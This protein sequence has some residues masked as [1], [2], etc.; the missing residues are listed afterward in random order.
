MEIQLEAIDDLPEALKSAVKELDEGKYAIDLTQLAPAAELERFKGKALKAEQEA[1]DRRKALEAYKALGAP[2]EIKSAL[3]KKVN[4]EDQQKIVEQIKAEYESK[5]TEKEQRL[6]SVVKETA[7]AS[8][9]AELAKA[10]VLPD[11]LDLVTSALAQRVKIDE[12]GKVKILAADGV[13]PMIGS[14]PDGGATFADL[15]AELSKT[16]PF[17]FADAGKGGGGKP[18]GSEGGTPGQKT[19]KRAQFE[20]MSHAER[21]SFAKDGG[22]VID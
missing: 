20:A 16:Q 10:G 15:A 18:P 12:E 1:I 2:D 13:S 3:E 19:I 4:A 6:H 5:L 17:I 9:K 21:A 11:A 8:M 22:K 7:V 14:A